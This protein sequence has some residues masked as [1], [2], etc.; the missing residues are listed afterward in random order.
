MSSMQRQTDWLAL[1]PVQSSMNSFCSVAGYCCAAVGVVFTTAPPVDGVVGALLLVGV[2]TSRPI[3]A[4]DVPPG[5][6][7]APVD[8]C[9]VG[10]ALLREGVAVGAAAVEAMSLRSS[11][12]A[13]NSLPSCSLSS[14]G[15][16]RPSRGESP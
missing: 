9:G 13:M 7:V 14:N 8:R 11:H 16:L 10:V 2:V 5:V 1:W 15:S 6:A 4:V 12:L 3:V